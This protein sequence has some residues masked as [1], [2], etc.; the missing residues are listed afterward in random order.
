MAFNG[1]QRTVNEFCCGV[2]ANVEGCYDYWTSPEQASEQTAILQL[3]FS[4][5]VVFKRLL[6][7]VAYYSVAFWAMAIWC[8]SKKHL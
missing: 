8:L 5:T 4:F 6:S 1:V 2:R 7:S 3:R